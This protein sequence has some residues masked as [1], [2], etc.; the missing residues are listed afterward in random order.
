[1]LE[2]DISYLDQILEFVICNSVLLEN[3]IL[4]NDHIVRSQTKKSIANNKY[5]INL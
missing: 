5:N 4:H 1:M 2:N 3:E